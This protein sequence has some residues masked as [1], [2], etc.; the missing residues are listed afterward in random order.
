MPRTDSGAAVVVNVIRVC[1]FLKELLL[2]WRPG[3]GGEEEGSQS[4]GIRRE[5]ASKREGRRGLLQKSALCSRQAL[6]GHSITQVGRASNRKK[7]TTKKDEED[8]DPP[9]PRIQ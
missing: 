6:G 8:G 1:Q 9:P 2:A 5:A 3:G 7:T 4:V